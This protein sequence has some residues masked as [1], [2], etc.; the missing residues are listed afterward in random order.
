MRLCL[1]PTD[2]NKAI[3]REHYH[4][5]SIDEIA[6]MLSGKIVFSIVDLKN[7]Y[8]AVPLDEES[9]YLTTFN[10]PFSRCRFHRLAFGLKSA[11][12]VFHGAMERVF[13]DIP[14]Y[15]VF[16]NDIICGWEI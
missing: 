6:S 14:N 8:W 9:L 10:L 2:S 4:S 3:K 5:P 11:A 15:Y 13:G 16:Y 7:G 1:D 12:E